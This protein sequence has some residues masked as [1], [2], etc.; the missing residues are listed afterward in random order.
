MAAR[1]CNGRRLRRHHHIR[2]APA[3][4]HPV[5][6]RH[7][8]RVRCELLYRCVDFPGIVRLQTL[9]QRAR[10]GARRAIGP[11][12]VPEARRP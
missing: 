1:W 7:V 11:K 9:D 8:R 5:I 10:R 6:A 4:R 2:V 12:L 3:I